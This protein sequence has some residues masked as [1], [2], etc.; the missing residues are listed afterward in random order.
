MFILMYYYTYFALHMM[1]YTVD[2]VI[3]NDNTDPWISEHF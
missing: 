2:G 1:L 3:F